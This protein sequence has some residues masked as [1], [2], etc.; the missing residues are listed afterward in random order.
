MT[1]KKKHTRDPRDYYKTPEWCVTGLYRQLPSLPIP[2]LDPCAGTGELVKTAARG[3]RYKMR[4]LEL[5]PD[6]V[7]TAN[8]PRVTQGDGLATGWAGEHVLMNPPY[9]DAMT[10]LEKGVRE[11]ASMCAL[12]RLGILAGQARRP[13]WVENPPRAIA[14]LSKRPSFT[15]GGVDSSDYAWIFWSGAYHVPSGLATLA[16]IPIPEGVG[17]AP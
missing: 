8:D 2:T 12:L 14:V 15:G 1:R 5:D 7:A 13:W 10:W 6:L 17:V 9:K 3:P 11:A 4:G 16:W